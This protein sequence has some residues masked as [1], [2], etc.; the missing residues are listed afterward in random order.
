MQKMQKMQKNIQRQSTFNH[1][2]DDEQGKTETDETM[3]CF[4]KYQRLEDEKIYAIDLFFK[5]YI[6]NAEKNKF[7]PFYNDDQ[8]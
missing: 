3:N 8:N 6:F 7:E 1:L 2:S 4:F 5:S